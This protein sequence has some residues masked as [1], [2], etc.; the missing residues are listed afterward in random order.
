MIRKILK[1]LTLLGCLGIVSVSLFGEDKIKG[2]TPVV[3]NK[4]IELYGWTAGWDFNK[5]GI[6]DQARLYR[7]G[8]HSIPGGVENLALNSQEF[9]DLQKKYNSSSS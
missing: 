9:R 3:Y 1:S 7:I 6:L 8:D 4:P 2:Q 5:D